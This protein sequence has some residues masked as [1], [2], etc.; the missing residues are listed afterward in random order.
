MTLNENL[1]MG[2]MGRLSKGFPDPNPCIECADG[3]EVSVQCQGTN[4][5]SPRKNLTDCKN[6]S[7][8]ELGFPNMPDELINSY[9]E[10]C[11]D[12]LE[13]VY[14]YVPREVVEA[15]VEKHGGIAQ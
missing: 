3:Y 1:N 2:R 9:A 6:Y 5:C 8:F 14:P 10:D 4:Y 13:T 12:L 15:L 7:H 11:N